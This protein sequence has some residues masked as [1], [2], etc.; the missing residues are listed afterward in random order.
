MNTINYMKPVCDPANNLLDEMRSYGLQVDNLHIDRRIHRVDSD[1]RGDQVGWYV[2]FQDDDFLSAVFGSWKE[3]TKQKWCSKNGTRNEAEQAIFK[4]RIADA[5]EQQRKVQKKARKN[6]AFIWNKAKEAK[7][8]HP[9]LIKKG[10]QAHGI[11]QYKGALVIPVTDLKGKLLSV[12]FISRAGNKRFLSGGTVAGG[13]WTIEGSDERILCEGYAT[14]ATIH[15]A[16]GATV[17]IAFNAGN[18]LKVAEPGWSIAGDNDAFTKDKNGD[19]WNPGIEKA[20]TAAWHHNC[21]VVIPVFVDIVTKPTDFN[22]LHSLEGLDAVK[23]QISRAASPKEYL[24]KECEIDVGACYRKEH[25]FGLKLFRERNKAGY[26][27]LRAKLKKFKVGISELE[28]TIFQA[29]KDGGGDK[30]DHLVLAKEVVLI[31]GIEN[32][33]HAS[34]FTWAWNITGVWEKVDDRSIKQVIHAKVQ[35]AIDEPKKSDVDSIL[36]LTKTEIFRP[37]HQWDVN[38]RTI[39]CLNGEFHWTGQEWTLEAHCREHYRTTQIP[40]VHDYM[41]TAPRTEQFL[42]EVFKG[43]PDCEEKQILICE[44]IGYTLL[45]TARYEKFILLIGP[46]ANGK[47]VLMDVIAELVGFPNV[48]A[49]QPSQFEN[50]FQRAH[51]HNKLMNCVTELAQGAEIHDAQLKAIVSGELTTAEHKHKPPFDFQPY[52]TCWFGSNHMPH[53]RDFSDALFRR[54]IIIPF[55][56]VFTEPE[57]DKLLKEKLKAELPG[58][59]NLALDGM[60]GVLERG[61]FTHT[62]SSEIAKKDWRLNADQAAEFASEKCRFESGSCVESG[63]LYK[64]YLEWAEDSGIRRTLNKKTLT[65]RMSRLGA[66][67]GKGTGGIRMLFGVDLS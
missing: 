67:P 8:D 51:L 39:N 9:Y 10:I 35:D 14:A 49:V 11:R 55:N 28:K 34:S 31:F 57:Q 38:Q 66:E 17:R 20:L 21:L 7:P 32:I 47:S 4:K 1:R 33:I 29:R 23:E 27:S 46:G 2:A 37:N 5:E 41:A 54:A 40:V 65:Q 52:S 24:L 45:S 25:L 43:D 3:G 56:R 61:F 30:R 18:L 62:E 22:D 59:L 42:H 16:T 19:P 36:D 48:C 12:Q 58:I 64:A 26:M 53:T 50:R 63:K 15:E 6:A 60:A 13:S 44:L